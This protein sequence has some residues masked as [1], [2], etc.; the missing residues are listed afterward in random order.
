MVD[1]QDFIK[2]ISNGVGVVDPRTSEEVAYSKETN[3]MFPFSELPEWLQSVVGECSISYG[4]PPELWAMAFL[5]GISA[6]SG[7]KFKLV[8]GNYLNYPQLW[9]MV[10]GRSG[11]G[12]SEAFRVAFRELLNIDERN[13]AKYQLDYQDWEQLGKNGTPPFWKQSIINDVTPE[14]LFMALSM[15]DNGLTL[16]RD[17]LSGWFMDIGRYNN[18]GEVGH[19][20]SIFDNQSFSINRKN[21]RPRLIGNPLMNICGTIQPGVLRDVL[22]MNNAEESGFAQRFLY[23]YPDFKARDFYTQREKPDVSP[24]NDVIRTIVEYSNNMVLHL[25]DEA[26][27]DY[28]EFFH[29]TEKERVKSDDFWAAVYSKSEIQALRLALTVKIARLMDEP[30][31]EVS[32]MDMQAAIGITKYCISS[33]RKFK[34]EIKQPIKKADVIRGIF[35]INPDANHYRI[36]E[37]LNVSRPFV[38]KQYKDVKVTR[39]PVTNPETVSES[40]I[41]DKSM[42]TNKNTQ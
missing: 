15:A 34:R 17:E 33:L 20:T 8:T 35:E 18:S 25:S 2:N 13:Y 21:D 5:C 4:T 37:I 12:K 1:L 26:E 22:S 16:Y 40:D 38:S 10:I 19:Y 6:A 36:A 23:L 7:K 24:Y 29:E 3:E 9:V 42:V 11:D 32:Q 31:A 14:A 41:E 39:L 28:A 30:D 27:K